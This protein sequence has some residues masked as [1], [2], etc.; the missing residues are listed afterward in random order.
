MWWE[1]QNLNAT[2][3]D[4]AG[5]RWNFRVW[6]DVVDGIHVERMFF[7]N[8]SRDSTGVAE[9]APGVHVKQLHGFIEKLVANP[10]L[11]ERHS[12]N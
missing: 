7:W 10:M 11:F 8:E 9:F 4:K 12:T 2:R 5:V 1:N 3:R 6:H